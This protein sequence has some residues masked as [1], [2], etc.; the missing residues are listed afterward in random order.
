MCFPTTQEC[1]E[2]GC[3][4]VAMTGARVCFGHA[5]VEQVVG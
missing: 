3:D 2:D 1:T 4:R 5:S